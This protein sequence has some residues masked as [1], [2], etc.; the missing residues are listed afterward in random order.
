MRTK[1]HKFPP[2]KFGPS[3]QFWSVVPLAMFPL[4]KS[5][6]EMIRR[7]A[8]VYLAE[9]EPEWQEDI[10]DLIAAKRAAWEKKKNSPMST[11]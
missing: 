10:D 6:I 8:Y 9:I 11:D 5:L 7:N 1:P 3:K 4:L 2:E